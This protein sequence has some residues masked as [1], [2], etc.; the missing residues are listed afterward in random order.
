M[1]LTYDTKLKD[2][3]EE[4]LDIL[5][6]EVKKNFLLH[7]PYGGGKQVTY[8]HKYSGVV[9]YIKHYYNTTT[10]NNIREWVEAYMNTLKCSAAMA[11]D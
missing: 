1:V 11:E 3:N 2:L 4:Q 9:N 6:M 10:S 7:T 5:L 8:L